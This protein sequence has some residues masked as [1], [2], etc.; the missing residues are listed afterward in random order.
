MRN[1]LPVLLCAALLCVSPAS[2]AEL[3]FACVEKAAKGAVVSIHIGDVKDGY[4]LR[5]IK[6][7]SD[8][9]VANTIQYAM[10][11]RAGGEERG[12]ASM[13]VEIVSVFKA[14][15][16]RL[17]DNYTLDNENGLRLT[18]LSFNIDAPDIYATAVE[19]NYDCQLE[20][21]PETAGK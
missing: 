3:F 11:L 21:L 7:G 5:S 12:F 9:T 2:A 16:G 8:E 13:K 14:P 10:T 1:L 17:H 6:V 15:E 18:R 20:D 4:P 19:R